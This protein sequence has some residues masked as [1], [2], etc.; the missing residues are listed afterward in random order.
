MPTLPPER[1]DVLL[2]S[3]ILW[4]PTARRGPPV[5]GISFNLRERSSRHSGERT[6][7]E[8]ASGAR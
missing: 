2:S 4:S 3:R 6:A 1:P 5:Q 8:K 7:P